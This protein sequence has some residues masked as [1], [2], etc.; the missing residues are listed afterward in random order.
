MNSKLLSQAIDKAL[1][2]KSEYILFDGS[3]IKTSGNHE[4]ISVKFEFPS[5]MIRSDDAAIFKKLNSELEVNVSNGLTVEY[6][7]GK[8]RLNSVD[9]MFFLDVNAF[10]PEQSFEVSGDQLK[11]GLDRVL[12]TVDTEKDYLKGVWFMNDKLFS[13]NGMQA[14]WYPLETKMD[15]LLSTESA[16]SLM[17]IIGERVLIEYG[18]GVRFTSGDVTYVTQ[19]LNA[20]KPKDINLPLETGTW[21]VN[22]DEFLD[23]IR[24]C[25]LFSNRDIKTIALT[26]S[27][28]SVILNI[29]GENG[30]IEETISVKGDGELKVNMDGNRLLCLGT[31][32]AKVTFQQGLVFETIEKVLILP[33]YTV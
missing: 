7:K 2:V 1:T 17:R 24:R 28:D 21:E 13:S 14:T 19:V 26:F 8:F 11:Y 27:K 9:K 10:E 6:D 4:G 18:Q 23:S 30:Q 31:G 15:F 29:D 22:L 3:S 5:C 32:T 25:I 20:K 33:V 12:R 16:R